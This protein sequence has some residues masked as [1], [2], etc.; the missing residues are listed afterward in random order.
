[1]SAFWSVL[2]ALG[3][4]VSLM[5]LAGC[6]AIFGDFTIDDSA[7]PED[8]TQKGP[9]RLEPIKGL[10]TTEW[11]GQATFTIVLDYAPTKPVTIALSSSNEKEGTLT[12]NSVTFTEDDWK[13]PQV[14][15]V[16]GVPDFRPDG[17]QAYKIITAPA[18]SE[19]K[20]WAGMNASD[21]TLVNIDNETAG[22]T[23]VP[24]AGLVTSEGGGQ[25]TF[26]VVLNSEPKAN[27]TIHLVSDNDK[28]GTVSPASLLFTPLNW[29][30]PQ[31]GTVTGADDDPKDPAHPYKIQVTSASEDPNYARLAPVFVEVTNQDN[32]SAGLSVALVTGVDPIDPTKLRTSESG[33]SA[34]FTVALTVA[35]MSDVSIAVSSN[36]TNEGVVSTDVLKFTPLNWNAPQ[37][38]TVTGQDDAD[39]T[40]DGDQPYLII[41][42]VLD[43][44]DPEY[45]ML[46]GMAISASNVDN[47][48]PG[49][50]VMLLSGI[51]PLDTSKL[52]T[53]EAGTTA[54]FSLALNSLPSAPVTV[55]VFSSM[56][57]EG[58]VTPET[59][60]FT[61][62]NWQSPQTVSVTGV[63]DNI[64]DGSPLFYVRTAIAE[65]DDQAYVLDPPDVAVTN[66]DDDSAGVQVTLARG[67]DPS[68]PN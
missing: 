11:G 44:Q 3:L 54:S 12:P 62:L 41:L 19:V 38:V 36:A 60:V 57:S 59:L 29:K 50:T 5:T 9:I 46:P 25:D 37:T 1:M 66:Q 30:S 31:L 53:T 42:G 68:T 55:R 34:T 47:E 32:D 45:A 24:M 40:A 16:T 18:V 33:D 52:L 13:A 4:A 26:T 2:R 63:G 48:K 27:V 7:F 61:Q 8:D 21:V 23:V 56:P 28:E 39:E 14:I 64:Q 58:K 43:S 49:F 35:P 22:V 67:I 6:T 51:D 17:N 65:S 15:T 20:P 10:Y